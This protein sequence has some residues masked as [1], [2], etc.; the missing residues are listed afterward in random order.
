MIMGTI[1]GMIDRGYRRDL[2]G[3]LRG[4]LDEA[5]VIGGWGIPDGWLHLSLLEDIIH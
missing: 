1:D 2:L 5:V 3:R 4:G